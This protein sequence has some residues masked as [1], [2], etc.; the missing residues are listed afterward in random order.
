MKWSIAPG[1]YEMEKWKDKPLNQ[2]IK[3]L[4]SI[5]S[6]HWAWNREILTEEEATKGAFENIISKGYRTI[7]VSTHAVYGED[8]GEIVFRDSILTQDAIDLLEINTHRLILSACETGVGEQNQGEGILS[9][10]WNFAY[11]GVPS[12]T[13]THWKVKQFATKEIIVSY[14]EKLNDGMFAD[15]ALREAQLEYLDGI[16]LLSECSPYYWAAFFHTGNT[17]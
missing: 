17:M 4:E 1:E 8:G 13:M 6:L 12:I 3:E 16:D 7:L 15:Q 11:K 5:K 2:A 9:L 10:G 14:S